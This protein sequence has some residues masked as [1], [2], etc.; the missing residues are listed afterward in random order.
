MDRAPGGGC[1]DGV[2]NRRERV[3]PTPVRATARSRRIDIE[4]RARI[5]PRVVVPVLLA[6]VGDKGTVVFAIV[7]GVTIEVVGTGIAATA[8]V[9][10]RLAE[11]DDVRAVVES[12]A[13][14]AV[15]IELLERTVGEC[16]GETLRIVIEGLS[17]SEASEAGSALLFQGFFGSGLG[18]VRIGIGGRLLAT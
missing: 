4:R 1:G 17:S 2:S 7:Y 14:I 12:S 9:R 18:E 10:V 11:V 13:A 3:L 6:P 15:A 8:S 5:S 16:E